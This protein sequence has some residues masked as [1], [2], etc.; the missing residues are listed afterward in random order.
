MEYNLLQK[1]YDLQCDLFIDGVITY[2][3]FIYLENKYLNR[4]EL[5]IINL[6]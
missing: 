3:E 6:N 4:L 2:D 1:T 5:F